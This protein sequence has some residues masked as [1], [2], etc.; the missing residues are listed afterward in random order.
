MRPSRFHLVLI[1]L[2]FGQLC[3][4]ATTAPQL[5]ERSGEAETQEPIPQDPFEG[6]SPEEA[7]QFFQAEVKKSPN[8][9]VL[10]NTLGVACYRLKDYACA[11]EAFNKGR[12]LEPQNVRIISSLG[13]LRHRQK[14]NEEAKKLV[15]EALEIDPDFGPA[16]NNMGLI[17][18]ALGDVDGSRK[19]FEQALELR[20]NDLVAMQNLGLLHLYHIRDA[21]TARGYLEK[22]L[23]ILE[24][25]ERPVAADDYRH[26]GVSALFSGDADGAIAFLTKAHQLAPERADLTF[27]LGLAYMEVM[28]LGRA[29]ALLKK[30]FE[31]APRYP[32][33]AH[34]YGRL[35]AKM[36][37][38][39][40]A[41]DVLQVAT[42]VDP[43]DAEAY[44]ALGICLKRAGKAKASEEQFQKACTLGL[45]A[46]CSKR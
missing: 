6:R 1:A 14:Q 2:A 40:Q 17:L 20:P 41:I 24:S 46:A 34:F 7:R 10:W 13:M 16:H 42:V 31:Q 45:A 12:E 15:A 18:L 37:E 38:C 3:A 22:H 9:P 35:L 25:Y 27:N 32:L 39:D 36:K 33:H 8:D 30:A 11:E 28:E 5:K 4:C 21:K 19:S 29:V 26:V 44:N 23:R 43:E